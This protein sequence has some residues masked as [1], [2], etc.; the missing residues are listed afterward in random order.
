MKDERAFEER[1]EEEQTRIV[2]TI[3]LYLKT[4]PPD[5]ARCCLR[6]L[7]DAAEM[8]GY[9]EGEDPFRAL[10]SSM[11]VYQKRLEKLARKDP[12]KAREMLADLLKGFQSQLDRAKK[13]RDPGVN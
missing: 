2:E 12:K 9:I 8:I 10:D 6:T 11:V 5:E 13:E 4:C 7:I 3:G 1:T